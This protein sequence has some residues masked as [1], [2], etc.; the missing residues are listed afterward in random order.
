MNLSGFGKAVLH[1]IILCSLLVSGAGAVI[2]NAQTPTG[3]IAG[4]IDDVTG[5][6]IGGANV[7][8]TNVDTTVTYKA[9][10]SSGG[11]YVLPSLPI[12]K[13]SIRVTA[14]G[15]ETNERTGLTVVVDQHAEVDFSLQAGSTTETVTVSADVNQIESESHSIGTVVD[16]QQIVQL[17]LNSRNFTTLA[18]IVPAV[19]PPVVNSSLGFR[20]GFNVAGASEASNTSTY[21]GFDNNNDQQSIPSYRPSVDAIAEFKVLTG[22]YDAEY[23]RNYGGQLVVTGKTGTNAFHGTLYEYLRNQIFDGKNFFIGTGAKPY[24][25]RN[26]FGGTVG[27]PIRRDKTFFFFGYE[28]LRDREQ[29]IALGSVPL[30]AWVQ[31]GDLS[32]LLPKVQLKNP[33]VAGSPNILNNN[34]ASL[35]QWTAQPAVVGRALAAYYPAPTS[36]TA[37]GT[38]PINNYNFNGARWENSDQYSLRIDQTFS[39]K[40]SMYGEYNWYRDSSLEPSN[41]LCG[42]RVLPGFGCY[43]GLPLS[44]SGLSETHVFRA[45]LL[46]SAR[47]GFN[48]YEQSRL[49]QDGN[50]NFVGMHGLTNVFS[51]NLSSNLGIPAATVTSFSTVGGPNNI[52][53][54]FV[55]NTYNLADQV[56]YIKGAQTIKAGVDFRRIQQNSLSISNGR[57]LFAFSAATSAPTTGF[58]FADLLLGYPSSTT[59]NPFGPKIYIRTSDFA[60]YFQ[61]DWKL[62]TRLTLNLG[63]RWELP[64]PFVSTNNQLSN[65]NTATGAIVVAAVNGAPRNLIQYDYSK[66]MPRVGFSYSADSKTVLRGGYGIY[67]GL[68]PTFSPIGNL[69]YNPPMRDPQTFQSSATVANAVTL[70]NPFPSNAPAG[71]A[72]VTAI[73][74]KFITPYVQEFGLG[75][76]RQLTANTLIDV[77]YYG[78]KGTHLITQT[79]I[80]QPPATTLATAAAVNALRPYPAYGNIVDYLSSAASNYSALEVKMDKRLS[81]G[82]NGLISYTY[83]KS[84]DDALASNPQNANNIRAEYGNSV[85]DARQRLVVSGLYQLPFGRRGQWLKNGPVSYFVGGWEFSGIFSAQTGHYLTPIYAGNVSNTYNSSDRPNLIGNPN[86]GPKTVKEWF[87]TTAAFSKPATGTFGNAGRDIIEAPGYTDLDATLAR[88][89]PLPRESNLQFRAEFFNIFNHPNFDPPNVTADSAAFGSISSAEAPRQMQFALRVSF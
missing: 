13:Y 74:P 33:F 68:L 79:N 81:H 86:A 30:P 42:S 85:F 48:R 12:G 19:Y 3:S 50:I 31:N 16:A 8:A 34:L 47:L 26:Q 28:G 53:Q 18:F 49:Q 21:D 32:S 7:V 75:I 24:Y 17:P 78:S 70:A 4:L 77:S 58:A 1:S 36:S 45:N 82:L 87:N 65:F 37:S 56:I 40:D 5:A 10:A 11:I 71:T 60:T 62:L 41:S 59:N 72:T 14:Q 46:N 25:K 54:D 15:F 6:A 69:Y 23:G 20:G 55:N 22:L 43:S 80:N 27:G 76:Q 2:A 52:P 9:T 64:T 57:G 63:M 88:S 61:D 84:L 83:S 73:N 67:V 44:V 38:V 35:P 29:V 39:A 51:Q 89:F 66:F